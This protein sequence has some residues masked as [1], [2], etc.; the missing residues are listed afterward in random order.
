MIGAVGIF[1]GTSTGFEPMDSELVLQ[2]FT[3][4]TMK[5]H[6]LGE[7]NLLSFDVNPSKEWS[8]KIMWTQEVL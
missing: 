5:T 6:T 8:V 7:A 2:C 4:W 1:F 3:I